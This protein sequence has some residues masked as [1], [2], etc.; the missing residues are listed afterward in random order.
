MV[1]C[2]Q[3]MGANGWEKE[4]VASQPVSSQDAAGLP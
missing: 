1:L 4:T 2:C 3:R